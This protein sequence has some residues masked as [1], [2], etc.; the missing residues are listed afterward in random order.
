MDSSKEKKGDAS[1]EDP[2]VTASRSSG[3]VSD[4]GDL[5][6][7]IVYTALDRKASDIHIEPTEKDIL[8]RYR[9]DGMLQDILL[10]DKSYEDELIFKVKI[11]ARLRTDEHFAPQDGRIAFKF[12]EVGKLDTRISILPTT[13]GEKIVIRLLTKDAKMLTLE[14]LGVRGK[15]LEKVEKAYN[16]PWGMILAVGPTGSGKTTSLY[17][18]LNNI[19][20]REKNITTIEDPVEFDIDGVNHIQVNPNGNLTF[21]NG[22]R[23]ILRQDPDIVMVGEIRDT[24]TARIAINAAMTGHLVLSTLHTNDAVTTVPRLIDMGVEAYLVAATVNLIVAQRLARLL[25]KECKQEYSLN[26]EEESDLEAARPDIARKIKS[27]QKFFKHVGCKACGGI[28]YKGRV[29][30]YEVLE[31]TKEMREII[32]DVN[33]TVDDLYKQANKE[34]L[35]TLLDDGINKLNEGLIDIPELIRVTAL[36]E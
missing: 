12:P 33:F 21:A 10:I 11:S 9:I 14:Q 19:N 22:L 6:N 15:S 8:V 28:G 13:K 3:D 27:G 26:K 16:K 20:S 31:L 18:I 36:N 32:N 25:C 5:L 17:S 1:K 7:N 29:G 34:G 4:I 23:S 30:L 24:E 2:R 35:V